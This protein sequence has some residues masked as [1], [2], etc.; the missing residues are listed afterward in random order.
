[1]W[2]QDKMSAKSRHAHNDSV[3]L[4]QKNLWESCFFFFQADL[5]EKRLSYFP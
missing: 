2:S 5:L 1:M 4:G 3:S